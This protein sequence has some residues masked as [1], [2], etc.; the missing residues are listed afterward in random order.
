[1]KKYKIILYIGILLILMTGC[2]KDKVEYVTDTNTPTDSIGSDISM[3]SVAEKVGVD[4]E[5]WEEAVDDATVKRIY[6]EVNVPD[7]TSMKV[8][9][10]EKLDYANSP[11]LKESFIT[12]V[13]DTPVYC[14]GEG[15][16]IKE[17]LDDD[18]KYY[19]NIINIRTEA[20]EVVEQE[21][22]D[23]YNE[24]VELYENAPDEYTEIT[25]FSG[26]EYLFTS[27]TNGMNYIISFYSNDLIDNY[28]ISMELQNMEDLVEANGQRVRF[29]SIYYHDYVSPEDNQC[30]ISEE[31]ALVMAEDFVENLGVGEFDLYSTHYLEYTFFRGNIDE[32]D[33]TEEEKLYDGYSFK[34]IRTVDGIF[35]VNNNF[36]GE[37]P[38]IEEQ[39]REVYGAET[40]DAFFGPNYLPEGITINVSSKGIVSFH[41]GCPMTQ[42]ET[43]YDNVNLLSYDS[44]KNVFIEEIY[45][46]DYYD[47]TTFRYLE[48]TYFVNVDKETDAHTMVPVWL[49]YSKSQVDG[50]YDPEYS[51]VLI[52]AMDGSVIN[53]GEQMMKPFYY[54]DFYPDE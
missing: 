4:E 6:A 28:G 9:N 23:M 14:Y 35:C 46:K 44:V 7:V 20:G 33:F 29:D 42:Q 2:G 41:Y 49:L 11:E 37:Q 10:M 39:A 16:Y 13:T 3:T 18:V 32:Y 38:I 47:M 21:F 8:I 30:T 54:S 12:T 52:N 22:Y 43:L 40:D 27:D 53:V 17:E 45:E 15:Y 36:A 25:D 24:A 19:E 34:F 31:D 1:M 5:L 51:F 48:L 26:D 50:D